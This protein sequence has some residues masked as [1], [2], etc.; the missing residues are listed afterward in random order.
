MYISGFELTSLPK[1]R[2]N[3]LMKKKKLRPVSVFEQERAGNRSLD[4]H[5]NVISEP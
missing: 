4:K 3:N 5:T 2:T 1:S